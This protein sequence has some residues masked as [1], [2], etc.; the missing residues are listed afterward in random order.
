MPQVFTE[1]RPY[2]L[3][4][5]P[6]RAN[7]SLFI[8]FSL[9]NAL[10]HRAL[11]HDCILRCPPSPIAPPSTKLA[12]P[13]LLRHRTAGEKEADSATV[14]PPSRPH[15]TLRRASVAPSCVPPSRRLCCALFRASVAPSVVP[16]SPYFA[17]VPHNHHLA[18]NVALLLRATTPTS[19]LRLLYFC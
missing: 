14:T 18:T 13:V 8:I 11:R 7:P 12:S 5:F 15:C 4:R 17:T 10:R 6:N 2:R 19:I 9:A 3:F 16:P 1:T